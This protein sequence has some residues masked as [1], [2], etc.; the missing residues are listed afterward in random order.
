MRITTHNI[1]YAELAINLMMAL[2]IMPNCINEL[3]LFVLLLAI[4]CISLI[5]IRRRRCPHC[6]RHQKLAHNRLE[7]MRKIIE[8]SYVY[9][10]RK[11]VFH[12]KVC[13]LVRISELKRHLIVDFESYCKRHAH[14]PLSKSD[15]E[16]CCL[17][18]AGFSHK[19]LSIIYSHTNE[20]SIYV[21][22]AR[23]MK[24]L[25]AVSNPVKGEDDDKSN[26]SE[27][28]G[29]GAKKPKETI[30]DILQDAD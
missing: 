26:P 5:R 18:E 2:I 19:E 13:D 21:K 16:F 9:E 1:K 25:K 7:L 23:I 20:H 27:E 30:S 4:Y 12:R 3:L 6:A 17:L 29:K 11:D 8:M 15:L 24:K 14:L 10:P 28:S 22:K